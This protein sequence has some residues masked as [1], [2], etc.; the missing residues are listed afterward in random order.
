MTVFRNEESNYYL[1][2]WTV[3]VNRVGQKS[4]QRSGTLTFWLVLWPSC[5]QHPTTNLSAPTFRSLQLEIYLPALQSLLQYIHSLLKDAVRCLCSVGW[6]RYLC[7]KRGIRGQWYSS[8]RDWEEV[9]K[10]SIKEFEILSFPRSND[11]AGIGRNSSCDH[12][13]ARQGNRGGS[14]SRRGA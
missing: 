4:I 8:L 11:P 10:C 14:F 6:F 3:H 12:F 2:Y 9:S 1:N 7:R 13:L 5:V